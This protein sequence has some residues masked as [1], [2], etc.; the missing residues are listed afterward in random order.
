MEVSKL[1]LPS[2]QELERR[3]GKLIAER[4]ELENKDSTEPATK[5][6][7]S[8]RMRILEVEIHKLRNQL[9]LARNSVL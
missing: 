8:A 6:W 5:T 9:F 1:Q 7:Y 4:V 3:L 2:V